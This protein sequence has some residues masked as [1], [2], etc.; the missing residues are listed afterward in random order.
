MIWRVLIHYLISEL[1]DVLFG[2]TWRVWCQSE[3]RILVLFDQQD[4]ESFRS[5]TLLTQ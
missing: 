2:H 1:L 5:F 4:G 3:S